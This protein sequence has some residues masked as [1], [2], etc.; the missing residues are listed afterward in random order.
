MAH[1]DD[2]PQKTPDPLDEF[3]LA[4]KLKRDTQEVESAMKQVPLTLQPFFREQIDLNEELVSRFPNMPLMSVIRFRDLYGNGERGVATLSSQDGSASLIVDISKKNA[5]MQ[6]AFTYGSMLSMRFQMNE[7]SELDR[8]A[9]LQN[10][11]TRVNEIVF[12]W[13]Q[14]RWAKDYVICVPHPYYVSLLA[15]SPNN[16][17]AAVRIAPATVS[18]LLAWLQRFW[19]G[20]VKP[21]EPPKDAPPPI[22]STFSW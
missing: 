13:G 19:Y 12:L 14:S 6:F 22:S 4:D 7:L 3:V 17:E 1:A 18:S 8:Q 20:K 15:F 2:T 5:E 11:E 10:M 16:F 9:W 21:K